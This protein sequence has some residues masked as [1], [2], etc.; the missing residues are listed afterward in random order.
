LKNKPQDIVTTYVKATFKQ[1]NRD[2]Y[3]VEILIGRLEI[4][5]GDAYRVK[6]A[7]SKLYTIKQKEYKSFANFFPKLESFII[8][9]DADLWPDATKIIYVRNAFNNR[10]R[11]QLIGAFYENLTIYSRFVTKCEQFSSQM[12]MMGIWK[13]KNG[14][15]DVRPV[16]QKPTVPIEEK[17]E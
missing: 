7:T 1:F 12:K 9:A 6:K 5:Y 4:F 11:A 16:Y 15:K 10:L 14:K 13:K 17:M 3:S 8:T 2:L